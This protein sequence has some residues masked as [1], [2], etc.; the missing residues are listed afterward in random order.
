MA[1]GYAFKDDFETFGFTTMSSVFA[2]VVMTLFRNSVFQPV[3]FIVVASMYTFKGWSAVLAS[4]FGSS[5][6]S[7]ANSSSKKK[8]KHNN[9]NKTD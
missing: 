2:A 8:K 1:N 7:T 3:A 9:K 6:S 5:S 4:L